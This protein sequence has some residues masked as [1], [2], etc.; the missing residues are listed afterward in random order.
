MKAR[1]STVLPHRIQQLA[2]PRSTKIKERMKM[3]ELKDLAQCTFRPKIK[4]SDD[5]PYQPGRKLNAKR[6]EELTKIKKRDQEKLDELKKM[7]ELKECTFAPL[8]NISKK[9]M[10]KSVH[11][12]IAEPVK[13]P[14]LDLDSLTKP[15]RNF[16][17]EEK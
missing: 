4:V 13:P 3:K 11:Q 6:L 14:P 15:R 1:S 10:S 5:Q 2:E 17:D 8:T 9:R 7:K 16:E 12:N